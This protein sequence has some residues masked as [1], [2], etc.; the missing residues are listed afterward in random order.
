MSFKLKERDAISAHIR[1][2]NVAALSYLMKMGGGGYQKLGI[3]CDQ[4][5]NLAITFEKKDHDYC[6]IFTRVNECRDRQGIQANQGFRR[7]ETKLKHLHEIV[8]DKGN[9]RDGSVCLEGV[10]PIT[11]VHVL[12]NQPFQ[13]GQGCF[14]YTLSSQVCVWF[15]TFCTHRKGSSESKSRSVSNA[16]NSPSM[17]RPAMVSRASKNVFKKPTTST[18]TQRS[19]ERSCRKVESTRNAEFTATSGLDNLRQNLL[20]E[21]ISERASNLIT[22]KRK[23]SSIKHYESAWKKWCDWCS[24]REISPTRSNINYLLTFLAE[25]FEKGLE[26]KAIATYRSVISRF[27]AQLGTFE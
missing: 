25:L 19:T 1:M 5:R 8:S 17:A 12:E 2:D 23:T 10:T 6:R 27:M 7:M 14:S 26:Y 21:E 18:S 15:P 24:E 4:Q 3:D 13:S 11:P 9:T 22:N 20:A 16:Y